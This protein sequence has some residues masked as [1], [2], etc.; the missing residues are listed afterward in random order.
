MK[1]KK[2]DSSVQ[3]SSIKLLEKEAL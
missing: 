2:N 1:D 3:W